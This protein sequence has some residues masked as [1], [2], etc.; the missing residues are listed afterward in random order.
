MGKFARVCKVSCGLALA[1]LMASCATMS[2]EECQ[3]AQ[4]HEVGQRD[5][6]RGEPL[7][8]LSSRVEDCAKVNVVVDTQAYNDGRTAG[9]G[10]YC[11]IENAVPVGLSGATYAGVCPPSVE[12]AFVYRYQVAR[13]VYV[14]R[15]EVKSLDSRT[16]FLERRLRE[17]NRNE[18]DRMRGT[19]SD[20]ERN[21]IHKEIDDQRS[22]VRNELIETDRRIRR[23]RDEL[24]SA[25]FDL[26]SL[27]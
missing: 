9:L 24:R 16:E 3:L 12:P 4:W 2:P 6:A 7:S 15:N 8:L 19:N 1:M 27:R 21:R 18:E 10:S 25:E 20:A 14:L 5:G 11:R 23:K 13:A 26:S 17:L 22:G